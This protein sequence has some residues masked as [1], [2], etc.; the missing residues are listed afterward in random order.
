MS[1]TI[2]SLRTR[3]VR[4]GLGVAA[5]FA[6]WLLGV[7]GASASQV[8]PVF[9][10]GAAVR[11]INP[12]SEQYL[13]GYGY[14]AGPTDKVHDDLE[15]RAFVVGKGKDA[16]AF[17]SV[18]LAG[19]FAAYDGVNAPYG[20]DATREKIADALNAKGYDIGRESVII[21]VTHV[22][23][24]PTLVGIWGTIDPAYLKKV[25][26]QT[27]AAASE[28][29]DQARPSEL[30]TGV[31]DIRS[32]IWQNGQGT[33]HPDGFEY[34]NELPILWA[35][36]PGTRA[37]NA[38]YA[39]VPNHPDQF[40]HDLQ[41]S[42]DWPGYARRKLDQLNGGTAV[43]APGTLGRQ[44]PPGSVKTY[45][46]VV[47]Q[48]EIVANAIQRTMATA[49]PLTSDRIDASEQYFQTLADNE[50]LLLGIK[51][52]PNNGTG[53]CIDAF[54]FCTIPRS[55]A[56]PYMAPG[57]DDD[58]A[59]IG[60]YATTARIG[61]AVFTTNPG[62]AFPEV[63][64]AIRDGI[65]GARHV[66]TMSQ[67]GD[68][69]GYYYERDD[70]TE[71]QFGSSNFETYNVSGEL[72]SGNVTAALAGAE[73]IGFE[74]TPQIVHAPYNADV[75][76]RPGIQWYPD[77]LESSDPVVNLYGS[78]ARSQDETVPAPAEIEWNFD[79]G[80]TLTTN[81]QD[82]FDHTFPGPGTYDVVATVTGSNAKIRSWEQQIKVNPAGQATATLSKRTRAGATLAAGLNGGSG[83]L[84]AAHWTCQDG[85]KVSGLIVR[86]ESTR[87]GT[88]KVTVVDGAGET[89]AASV[90][91]TKAPPK[92]VAKLKITKA[93]FQPKK[94]KRGKTG[95]LVVRLKNTGNAVARSAKV[96]FK[97]PRK[98]RKAVK[99]RRNCRPAARGG[100]LA[101]GQA[102]TVTVRVKATRKAKAKVK[103]RVVASAKG[104]KNARKTAILR[105]RR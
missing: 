90:K 60:A 85:S 95:V 80:T 33:N 99:P 12:D 92:P 48:G 98:S 101:P 65:A 20:V 21:S 7:S 83:K 57:V 30:W 3:M 43:I 4:V 34:D 71:Q 23:A 52:N 66:A 40:N 17:V 5:A 29:A 16:L 62:E 88:A 32:F 91:V 77:T 13:G 46:E 31:G 79:D 105:T 63:N 86:C 72:P 68:M 97:V 74:T 6:V 78:S 10:V 102:R 96:C 27:V 15:T 24:A 26:D 100:K 59:T 87:A 84:I 81:N 38:L 51:L 50:E 64:F 94:L 1:L 28:A 49:T 39:N 37:T 9:D 67:T 35:R 93:K 82:R 2:R 54:E 75:L 11:N 42:A 8:L 61:D 18:D 44:E 22:H 103:V 69:L 25:S 73:A 56:A 41:M 76:D 89:A 53:V 70:Y 45:D 58:T 36:E 104:V 14:M 19:W 55:K 47:P